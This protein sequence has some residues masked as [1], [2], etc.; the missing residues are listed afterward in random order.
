[1]STTFAPPSTDH[2]KCDSSM[3]SVEAPVILD[4]SH[5][6]PGHKVSLLSH[7]QTLQLYRQNA[8]KTKDPELQFEFAAFM[9]EASRVIINETL[10]KRE[11]LCKEGMTLLKKLSNKGHTNSQ[12]Y[13]A[14]CYANAI[15][16]SKNKP[17][18][19]KAFSLFVQASKHDHPDADY[20]V[21]ICYEHGRGCRKDNVRALQFLRS[22]DSFINGL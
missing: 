17:D 2:S 18:F 9:I 8:K 5:L 22:V 12:Y 11:Q 14:D 10:E 16:T 6:K 15:G 21:G 1:M 3:I 4:Q 19:D 7:A 13:L 20:H